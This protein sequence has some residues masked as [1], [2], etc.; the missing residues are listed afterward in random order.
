MGYDFDI[1]SSDIRVP[2]GATINRVRRYLYQYS[3]AEGRDCGE[4]LTLLQAAEQL[5]DG[6]ASANLSRLNVGDIMN[7]INGSWRRVA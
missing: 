3:D 1:A 2:E 6:V 5:P 4:A 7:V